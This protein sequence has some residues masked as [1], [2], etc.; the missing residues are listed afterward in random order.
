MLL[1]WYNPDLDRF[2]KGSA[3]D[4]KIAKSGSRRANKFDVLYE[5]NVTSEQLAERILKSLNEVGNSVSTSI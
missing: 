2:E 5:F 1:I 3:N 4:L